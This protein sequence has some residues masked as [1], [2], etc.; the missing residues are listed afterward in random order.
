MPKVDAV[1][2]QQAATFQLARRIAVKGKVLC[3]GGVT[4][5][6]VALVTPGRLI[7][8]IPCLPGDTYDPDLVAALGRMVSDQKAQTISVIAFNDLPKQILPADQLEWQGITSKLIDTMIPFLGLLMCMTNFG[9]N[10]VVF[11]GHSSAVALGCR[12][13]DLLL[14]DEAMVVHLPKDW[15]SVAGSVLRKPRILF[16]GREG[17]ITPLDAASTER[18]PLAHQNVVSVDLAH[19]RVLIRSIGDEPLLL[20]MPNP[21]SYLP[22]GSRGVA[23][24]PGKRLCPRCGRELNVYAVKCRFCKSEL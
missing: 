20:T 15:V 14:V 23:P 8:P 9:H 18:D 3:P 4:E 21:E 19:L 16:W 24:E 10:V 11:E 17:T 13:A 22:E 1:R 12:D 2:T 6:C 7:I 5:R